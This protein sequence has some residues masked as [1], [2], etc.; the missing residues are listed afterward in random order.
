LGL[1]YDQSFP[2]NKPVLMIEQFNLIYNRQFFLS[3]DK[4]QGNQIEQTEKIQ[5]STSIM[6]DVE[7]THLQVY[8]FVKSLT[9]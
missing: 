6:L 4:N 5:R 9:E 3:S 1:K 8:K 7:R 2:A